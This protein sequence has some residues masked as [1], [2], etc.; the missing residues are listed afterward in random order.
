MLQG[1]GPGRATF[2]H[3]FGDMVSTHM[4]PDAAKVVRVAKTL[5]GFGVLYP[6]S[7]DRFLESDG[8]WQYATVDEEDE[9]IFDEEALAELVG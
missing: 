6:H 8:P 7:S 9:V 3:I 4:S 5:R 1:P 2:Y